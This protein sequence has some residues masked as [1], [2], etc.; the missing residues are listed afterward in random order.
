MDAKCE[1][2][3]VTP[4]RG[5]AV[6]INALWR[7]ALALLQAWTRR[8]GDAQAARSWG[9]HAAQ[10]RASFNHRFWHAAGDELGVGTFA[11]IFDAEPPYT[12]R[13]CISQARSVAEVPRHL[14]A[15]PLRF[16]SASPGPGIPRAG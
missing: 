11:E 14:S 1:G 13:G 3:V 2:W 8:L 6:E 15:G 5:K 10:A 16:T 4:R 12:P 7:N 9:E